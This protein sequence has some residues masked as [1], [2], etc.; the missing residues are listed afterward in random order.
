MR[1]KRY[2]D[3]G[4]FAAAAMDF[5]LR[6]EA[7]NNFFIGLIPQLSTPTDALL[8]TVGEKGK[9]PSAVA[10]MTPPRHMMLSD[11][12]P[13][14][15]IAAL[16]DELLRQ[17]VALPGIQSTPAVADRFTELWAPRAGVVLRVGLSMAL[18]RLDRVIRP[19]HGD[20]FLRPTTIDDVELVAEWVGNFSAEINDSHAGARQLATSAIE[21]QRLFA[22]QIGHR[23]VSMAA[24]SRPTPNG[25]AINLV[26]TPKELRGRGYASNCVAALSQRMLDAGKKFCT[27]YT[28]LANPTSN[29][30]YRTIGYQQ[31]SE[32]K[33]IFFD[34]LDR[35]ST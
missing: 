22:W 23:P 15:A 2:D 21:K 5:L 30:I 17:A 29:K 27:L 24:W 10:V 1:A 16:V 13:D 14:A 31:V 33:Q 28:D 20:G 11:N 9:P 25:C 32:S 3:A 34:P 7:R 18:H 8:M 6:D 19:V 35:S 26:Y 4:E 12:P